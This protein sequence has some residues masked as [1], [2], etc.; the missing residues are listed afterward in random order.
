MDA[1]R[2]VMQIRPEIERAARSVA[3]K[4]DQVTDAED[5]EQEI[6]THLMARPGSLKKLTEMEEDQRRGTLVRIGHQLA[7]E[8]RTRYEYFSGQYTYS[9][10]EVRL[11]LER[12]A[13]SGPV[14]GFDAARLDAIRALQGLEESSPEYA[15]GIVRRYVFGEVPD[16]DSA[17][18]KALNR[19]VDSLTNRMNRNRNNDIAEYENGGGR[20]AVLSNRRARRAVDADYYGGAAG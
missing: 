3:R 15:A 1:Q 7:S 13:L 8:E 17:A 2:L 6:L 20:R 18:R 5:L 12:K 9:V 10:D 14:E 19:A 11:L 4:W 16:R